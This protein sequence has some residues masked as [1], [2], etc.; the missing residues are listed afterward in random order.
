M[1]V[2]GKGLSFAY[3]DSTSLSLSLSLLNNGQTNHK[4]T[5][6][7][8]IYKMEDNLNKFFFFRKIFSLGQRLRLVGSLFVFFFHFFRNIKWVQISWLSHPPLPSHMYGHQIQSNYT[9]LFLEKLIKI[10]NF[11]VALSIN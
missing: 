7:I 10:S 8:P 2:W 9:H 3:P 1:F 6:T 4:L 11:D 5:H